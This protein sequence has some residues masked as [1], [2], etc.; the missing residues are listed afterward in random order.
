MN[1]FLILNDY[2]D[3]YFP[4]VNLVLLIPLILGSSFFIV[5]FT[6]DNQSSRGKLFTGC[7]FGIISTALVAV[8]TLCYYV[9]IYKKDG[10]YTGMGDPQ[11]NKYTKVTKKYYIFQ[12]LA[13]TAIICALFS[14]FICVTNRYTRNMKGDTS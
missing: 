8:W 1:F 9:W 6:K 7:M 14:Y 5:F 13:E 11:T 3:W 2:V 12:V 4:V 10:V